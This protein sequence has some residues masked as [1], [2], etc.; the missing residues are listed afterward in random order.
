MKSIGSPVVMKR[1]FSSSLFLDLLILSEF[2]KSFYFD[3]LNLL[4]LISVFNDI[5]YDDKI[6]IINFLLKTLKMTIIFW[7]SIA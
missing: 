5:R 3:V 7:Y 2:I 4:N 6:K 1:Q